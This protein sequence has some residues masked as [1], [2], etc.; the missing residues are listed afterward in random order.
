MH[1]KRK[2]GLLPAAL[3][4]VF[5]ASLRYRPLAT[6]LSLVAIAL[7]VALGLAVQLIHGAALS[8]FG[9]GLRHLAGEADL[10]VLGPRAGFD[11]SVFVQVATQPEVAAAS[12]VVE[13]EVEVVLEERAVEGRAA[14]PGAGQPP[15]LRLVGVDLFRVGSVSPALLPVAAGGEQGD[16]GEKERYGRLAPLR[17][18]TVFLSAAALRLFSL[19]IG[20][21][22]TLRAGMAP[23]RLRVGGSIPAAGAGQV[24]AVMDIAAV[25]QRFARMGRLSRIDLRLHGG[26]DRDALTGRW[27]QWLPA[28]VMAL[29]P[30]AVQAQSAGLSRAYRV[31][32]TML[33]GIAL[34]TGIFLVFSTQ[35][36]AVVRRRRELAFLRAI[37]MA[38]GTLTRGLL[39]EGALVGM[40]GGAA[41]VAL[42]Y[43]L[44][45]TMFRLAGG[46]LGAGFFANVT[47][48]VRF[49]PQA[50]L[51]YWLLG[52]LAGVGGAWL[53]AR[54]A[55]RLVPARAL[56]A[57]DEPAALQVR[58]RWGMAGALFCTAAFLCLAPPLGGVPV[59]GYLA[60]AAVLA[61]AM[62]SLPG[63]VMLA[64]GGLQRGPLG[65]RKQTFVWRL[66]RARLAAAPGQAV[67]AGAGIVASV[68]L[69]AAMAIM[70]A[71]F[72]VSVDDWL[73]RVLPADLYVRAAASSSISLMPP[74]ALERL[75]TIAGV[76]E[77]QPVRFDSLRMRET[78]FPMT[79]IARDVGD[80]AFL[81]LVRRA[82]D[83]ASLV[84][85]GENG[86]GEENGGK[87]R[88]PATWLSEAAADLLGVD[89]GQTIDVPLAGREVRFRIAGIWRDYARQTGA[90]IVELAEYRRLSGDLFS[91]DIGIR[92]AEGAVV[93]DVER[94]IAAA[95]APGAI[96]IVSPGR[97]RT[98]TLAVF[99]RTFFI[100][101]LMEAVAVLIGLFGIGTSFAALANSR[102]REFGML[103]HLG[104]R[105]RDI[106]AILSVEGAVTAAIAV[107]V[108]LLAGAAIAWIL[109]EVVNRQS[110]HWSMD[111]HVP[112][113]VLSVFSSALVALA[114]L[115]ARLAGRQAMR[116]RA[117]V[118]VREDW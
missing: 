94:A 104:L 79:L 2:P 34:L 69:A 18:D 25:Q 46:D 4:P 58:P 84:T 21:E 102:R 16:D 42:A 109:I 103:R 83:A 54:E 28:G 1:V 48:E 38:R 106:A 99:D 11:D 86:R 35:W 71:S 80:A 52:I 95:F 93:G 47:P 89:V 40:V 115:A 9:Q 57:G 107:G 66:A 53:P 10:Q 81:P 24:M 113:V 23:V 41:G 74:E 14:E 12:P 17:D 88:L 82:S 73:T 3:R 20:D 67:V 75:S 61:G 29:A 108:G 105:Q 97:I 22:V 87:A 19:D 118:A 91:N 33:A 111:M 37:G 60:I 27:R 101:Y 49:H 116:Q 5:V 85:E 100:T 31:N 15:T 50:S 68:A 90:L 13:A 92:L 72:R 6:L 43:A 39:A 76:G 51:V 7:G 59:A 78:Q 114:A 26:V 96:E 32:M 56:R 65:R 44:T 112:G 70:V 62:M 64:V 8:E 45:A 77:I 30:D 110:F 117:V 55:A 36:L 63:A 98:A